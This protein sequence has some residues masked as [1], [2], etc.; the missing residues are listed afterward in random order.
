MMVHL[1][2]ELGH[3][4]SAGDFVAEQRPLA[5]T[6]A[7]GIHRKAWEVANPPEADKVF[8]PNTLTKI[9]DT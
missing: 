4:R 9:S 5:K 2:G 7:A 8:L 3:A 1:G 6:K